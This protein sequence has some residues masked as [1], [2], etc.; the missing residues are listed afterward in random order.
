[1]KRA[2][3]PYHPSYMV[4]LLETRKKSLTFKVNL[5]IFGCSNLFTLSEF[6]QTKLSLPFTVAGLMMAIPGSMAINGMWPGYNWHTFI[7]TKVV[8][9]FSIVQISFVIVTTKDNNEEP[10][11]EVRGIIQC[12]L[13]CRFITR[14]S[15]GHSAEYLKKSTTPFQFTWPLVGAISYTMTPS[16]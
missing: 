13:H 5:F 12:R 9:S 15:T 1:M 14:V 8:S 6:Q 7:Q 3:V 16:T 2:V 4:A 10:G 11:C